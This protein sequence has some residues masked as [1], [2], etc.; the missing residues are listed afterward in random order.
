MVP[1]DCVGRHHVPDLWGWVAYNVGMSKPEKHS[2]RDF[3]QGRA[4]LRV[5]ADKAQELVDSASEL[6]GAAETESPMAH[7]HAT[8]RAMAC[9][10]AVQYHEADDD[11]GE[12]V[13][14][15]F[16]LIEQ[17]EDQ[18]TIYRDSSQ[19]IEINQLACQQAVEVDDGLFEL[20]QLCQQL[21]R[22]TNGAFDI[23]SGPLSR[24]WG[25]L[26]REGRVPASEELDSALSR[27]DGARVALNPSAKTVQFLKPGTEINFNSIGKGYA[28]DLVARQLELAGHDDFFWHGGGSSVLARGRNR[29]S[30]KSCW[31]IGLRHPVD[32]KQ[33]LAEFH[34]TDRALATAGGAT[35]FF[36]QEGQRYSHIL[37]PRTGQ[38]A[39]GVF[40]STV[41]A[42]TAAM[43]DGLATAFFVMGPEQVEAYCK[44]HP[45]IGAVLL[46]PENSD[47]GFSVM[48]CGLAAKEWTLLTSDVAC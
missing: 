37:D 16:D 44:L 30:K 33:R 31:T 14:A 20:L 43:A 5:A 35:Q 7:I 47:S 2:R 38:P 21:H 34:L 45:E 9:E 3:L 40:S 4:A 26:K 23:T 48:T 46:C 29:S 24:T 41:L 39:A 12:A 18:L 8:R 10:F 6:L 11:L 17:V 22:E 28:L 15:A 25:F 27:V 1:G 36:E 13:L 19:V 32:A 42:P